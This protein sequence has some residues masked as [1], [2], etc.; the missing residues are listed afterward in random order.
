[1]YLYLQ[2]NKIMPTCDK[3]IDVEF[4]LCQTKKSENVVYRSEKKMKALG[5]EARKVK[6]SKKT[7]EQRATD[8][9]DGSW[10]LE[11]RSKKRIH[12]LNTGFINR[13]KP[14][15][16]GR[17][18]RDARLSKESPLQA[19]TISLVLPKHRIHAGNNSHI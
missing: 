15:G 3:I 9:G 10:R 12:K 18:Q 2:Y 8:T 13:K 16:G 11:M 17:V 5:N 1:M 7:R 14:E 6:M 4:L 19:V